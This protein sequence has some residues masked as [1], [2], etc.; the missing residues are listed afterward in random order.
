MG[1]SN[2]FMDQSDKMWARG[3]DMI[4]YVLQRGG[5]MGNGFQVCIDIVRTLN[6]NKMYDFFYK[7]PSLWRE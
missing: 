3:K 6:E 1:F 7:D 4:K 5:R 2:Y